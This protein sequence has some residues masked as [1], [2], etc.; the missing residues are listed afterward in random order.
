MYCTSAV[1]NVFIAII[2]PEELHSGKY[3]CIVLVAICLGTL[4]LLCMPSI[5]KK[6]LSIRVC[7]EAVKK[8]KVDSKK[9][10]GL[11]ISYII[12]LTA[13]KQR[14]HHVHLLFKEECLKI[15]K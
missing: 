11:P 9:R 2:R 13:F 14:R 8:L 12:K 10:A 1:I 3:P 6:S 5:R 7:I 4:I 15:L